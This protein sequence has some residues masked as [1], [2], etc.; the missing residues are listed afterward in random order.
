MKKKIVMKGMMCD[1][2]GC[3]IHQ[4]LK[5]QVYD[6]GLYTVSDKMLKIDMRGSDYAI[7]KTKMHLCGRCAIKFYNM[8]KE[9]RNDCWEHG[10][11]IRMKYRAM[12]YDKK[13]DDGGK[14]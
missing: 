6:N 14:K 2:C 13:D 3:I 7:N 1:A 12:L 9:W 4:E 5:E 8:Y 10:K 11:P